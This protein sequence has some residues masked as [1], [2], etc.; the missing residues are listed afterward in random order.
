M[1]RTSVRL[2]GFRQINDLAYEPV[3]IITTNSEKIIANKNEDEDSNCVQESSACDQCLK[4]TD[5]TNKRRR[6]KC[7]E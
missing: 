4:P 2:Q 3:E 7:Y 5:T 6:S 1:F